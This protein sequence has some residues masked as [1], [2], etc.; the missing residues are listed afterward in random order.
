M[1][2]KTPKP[3]SSH[4]S[5]YERGRQDTRSAAGSRRR[6]HGEACQPKGSHRFSVYGVQGF[7][8][9]GVKDVGF[10]G[11]GFRGPGFRV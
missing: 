5:G 1:T 10:K 9:W 11:L 8:V 6:D 2:L 4:G 3:R 7:R